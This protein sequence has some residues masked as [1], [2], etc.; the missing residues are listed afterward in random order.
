MQTN[1]KVLKFDMFPHVVIFFMADCIQG[2]V[3]RK[4]VMNEEEKEK[5]RKSAASI[6]QWHSMLMWLCD[7]V[8]D[9]ADWA[10]A[11]DYRRFRSAAIFQYTVPPRQR[12]PLFLKHIVQY[13]KVL[14]GRISKAES[15]PH[16]TFIKVWL[17]QLL[18]C[19]ISRPCELVDAPYSSTKVGLRWCHHKPVAIKPHQRREYLDFSRLEVISVKNI[20]YKGVSKWI[21]LGDARLDNGHKCK[22]SNCPCRF[23]NPFL[24][25]QIWIRRIDWS[26]R[27]GTSPMIFWEN[28]LQ[29]KTTDLQKIINEIVSVNGLDPEDDYC[30]NT[31]RRLYGVCNETYTGSNDL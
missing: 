14:M 15:I 10:S 25:L 28:G 18:F 23:V 5:Y 29:V 13:S 30:L 1:A 7:L 8:D 9:P 21:N 26:K 27:K 2:Q 12:V 17:A 6:W 11:R 22:I 19:S 20:K 31:D 4:I 3:R 24:L 16:N